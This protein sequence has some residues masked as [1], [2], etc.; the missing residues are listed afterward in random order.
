[1]F[2]VAGRAKSEDMDW[3]SRRNDNPDAWGEGGQEE[4]SLLFSFL[5]LLWAVHD[6]DLS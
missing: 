1:M 6:A 2:G 5:F 3:M 4:A